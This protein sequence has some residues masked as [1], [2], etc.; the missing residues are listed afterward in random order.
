MD[1]SRFADQFTLEA[2]TAN[3]LLGLAG[4][5]LWRLLLFVFSNR[6]RS[7]ALFWPIALVALVCAVTFARGITTETTRV[8]ATI[9]QLGIGTYG[10]STYNS[11][12]AVSMVVQIKNHG[13]PT[14]FWDWSLKAILANGR[15]VYGDFT[16][17]LDSNSLH[18]ET[19]TVYLK[20]DMMLAERVGTTPMEKG[21]IEYGWLTFAFK[22]HDDIATQQDLAAAT[23]FELQF[24]DVLNKVHFV[25]PGRGNMM[26]DYPLSY[27]PNIPP[28]FHKGGIADS[29]T[30]KESR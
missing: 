23:N 24:R 1:F 14:A 20:R 2:I 29:T 11:P 25:T 22:R 27:F 8:D 21:R 10:V 6:P 7:E 4:A 9:L 13:I 17:P 3:L 5:I 12:G 16:M 28:S 26:S 30:L 19:G 15:T 18:F